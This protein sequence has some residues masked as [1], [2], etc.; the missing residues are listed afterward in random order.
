MI[1]D[2]HLEEVTTFD[3]DDIAPGVYLCQMGYTSEDWT[4]LAFNN[5]WRHL[6]L[7]KAFG[8]EPLKAFGPIA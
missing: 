4:C 2:L 7:D 8:L 1:Q 5:G 3:Y 6:T